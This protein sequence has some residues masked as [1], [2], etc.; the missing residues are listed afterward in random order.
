MPWETDFKADEIGSGF[1]LEP[2]N[3]DGLAGKWE[4][5]TYNDELGVYHVRLSLEAAP[6]SEAWEII[7]PD[8]E[9]VPLETLLSL[10]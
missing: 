8:E 10:E 6:D 4:L 7:K 9:G 5:S 1:I 3:M 2:A